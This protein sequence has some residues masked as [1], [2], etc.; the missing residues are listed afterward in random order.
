MGHKELIRDEC[1]PSEGERWVVV[2]VQVLEEVCEV[3]QDLVLCLGVK[4]LAHCDSAQ[5]VHQ[6]A[7][8]GL[9]VEDALL[10]EVVVVELLSDELK[11]LGHKLELV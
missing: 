8:V 6:D 9:L 7:V 1:E 5:D 2:R 10:R 3:V 4:T 11:D